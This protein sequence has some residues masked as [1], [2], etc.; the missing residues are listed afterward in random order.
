MENWRFEVW[1]GNLSIQKC[2]RQLDKTLVYRLNSFHGSELRIHI[3]IDNGKISEVKSESSVGKFRLEHGDSWPERFVR[4]QKPYPLMSIPSTGG[5]NYV[6][7]AYI[8][9]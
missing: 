5:Q 9:S 2:S 8:R 6:D 3:D 1:E 7:S 4:H